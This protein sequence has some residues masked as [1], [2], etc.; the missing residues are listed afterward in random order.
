MGYPATPSSH[1]WLYHDC[2]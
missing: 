2:F 1:S